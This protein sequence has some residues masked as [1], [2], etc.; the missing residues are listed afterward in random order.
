MP[1][2]KNL[3]DRQM[4]DMS[5]AMACQLKRLAAYHDRSVADL[6]REAIRKTYGLPIDQDRKSSFF[7]QAC[8]A[9]GVTKP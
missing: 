6:I 5:G 2:A 9:K 4:I 8:G 7:D 1:K 3:T